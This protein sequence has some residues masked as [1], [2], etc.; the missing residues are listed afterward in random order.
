VRRLRAMLTP[1]R[2]ALVSAALDD[3][4]AFAAG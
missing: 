1:K 2:P 4:L 3:A